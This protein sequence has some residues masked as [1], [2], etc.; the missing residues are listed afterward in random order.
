M[1]DISKHFNRSE[2]ACKCGCGFDTV[3]VKTLEVL[4]QLREYLM[5][6]VTI[7]SACR[8][9]H[10]NQIVGG[11][12]DSQHTK[13]RAAD[14]LVKDIPPKDVYDIVDALYPD[15][16][17]LGSYTGFTHIDTRSN[18]ARWEG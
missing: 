5:Q 3:D 10:Y 4:E 6:P 1:G 13:G 15:Q 11:A 18:K 14:I 2:F 16:F 7:T 17:G 9:S 8:C 12:H